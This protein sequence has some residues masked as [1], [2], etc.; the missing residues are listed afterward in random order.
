MEFEWNPQK[1]DANLVKHGIAFSE[2]ATVFGDPLA[3]TY[4]D[5]DHSVEEDRWLTFGST[6]SGLYVVVV[7]TDRGDRIRIISARRM[8]S[9]E[10]V[11]YERE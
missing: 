7:H 4:A 1:A 8:T 2:A 6:A 11:Q 3:V 10:R 5:P 9:R